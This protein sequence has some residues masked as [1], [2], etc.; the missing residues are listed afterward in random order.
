MRTRLLRRLR[1]SK[2]ATLVEAAIITP[3]LLLLTFSAIDFATLFFV[4]LSLQNGVNQATRFAITGNLMPGLNRENSIRT[5]MRQNTPTLTLAD[6]AF[7][8]S[9]LSPGA[10]G[11]A[12]GSGAPSDIEKVTVDYTWQIM[13]PLLRP[14]FPN[15]LVNF[16]VESSMKNESLFQ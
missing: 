14:F 5:A 15:G 2:G 4:N 9:H 6:N 7:T 8:F 1:D 3:L 12:G 16:R 11:W 13:T 10:G